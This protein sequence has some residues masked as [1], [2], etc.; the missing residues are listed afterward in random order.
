MNNVKPPLGIR[1]KHIVRLHRLE[2]IE[3]GIV[4]YMEH[5]KQIPVEWIDERNDIVRELNER[6][7]NRKEV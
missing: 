4:R 3:E 6:A 2:E 1:P 7:N 5:K